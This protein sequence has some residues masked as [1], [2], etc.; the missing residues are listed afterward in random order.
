MSH[1]TSEISFD[2]RPSFLFDR[3]MRFLMQ[4]V[5]KRIEV[6]KRIKFLLFTLAFGLGFGFPGVGFGCDRATSLHNVTIID[7]IHCLIIILS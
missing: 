7:F 3:M 6:D 5:D 4:L 2:S 1:G